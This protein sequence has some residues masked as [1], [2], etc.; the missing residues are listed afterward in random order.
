LTRVVDCSVV[1][2]WVLLEEGREAALALIGGE[3]LI[4]PDFLKLEIANVLAMK[5]RRGM[6]TPSGAVAGLR[7]ISRM[8]GLT[9]RPTPP[10][11]DAAQGLALELGQTA[12]DCL[13]LA[14]A[15]AEGAVLVTADMAF[16]RAVAGRP[17]YAGYVAAL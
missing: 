12:Y 10:Y 9:F 16:N 7:E 2:K 14:L 4:A 6:I 8:P 1:S 11:I 5:A 3:P 17:E 15:L 13:Y